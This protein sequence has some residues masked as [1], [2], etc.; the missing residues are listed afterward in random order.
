MKTMISKTNKIEFKAKECEFWE[1]AGIGNCPQCKLLNTVCLPMRFNPQDRCLYNA[2]YN[3][4]YNKGWSDG[5]NL[6]KV[7]MKQG[8]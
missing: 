7:A 5:I 6:Y 3:K 1:D 4:G 8:K 2:I